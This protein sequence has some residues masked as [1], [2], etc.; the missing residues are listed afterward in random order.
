[1]DLLAPGLKIVICGSDVGPKFLETLFRVA[2]TPR[3]LTA[4]ELP[5]LLEYRIGLTDIIKQPGERGANSE[6]SKELR[7]KIRESAP[8]TLV[9]NGKQPA[10]DYLDMPT[11]AY[12]PQ[13]HGIG[14]TKIF[15]CPSTS[16]AA[17]SSWEPQWWELMAKL[18]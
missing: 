13:K 12:G 1:M 5:A 17:K 8:G 9:F 16:P 18:A 3:E 2:L 7:R 14:G 10:K 6:G 15:V 11:V 4:E